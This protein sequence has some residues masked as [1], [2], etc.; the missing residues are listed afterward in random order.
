M[1]RKQIKQIL[2]SLVGNGVFTFMFGL[3]TI[4]ALVTNETTGL[5]LTDLS[6]ASVRS[7]TTTAGGA[8]L[9]VVLNGGPQPD[10]IY[11]S[12]DNGLSWQYLSDEPGLGFNILVAHP[13]DTTT[14]YGGSVGGAAVTTNSLWR[15][16]DG[17][18][19]W[20]EF[21]LDLPA[22]PNGQLPA[23]TALAV[24]P[25]KP[26]SFYVGT[27]GRGVYR[28]DLSVSGYGYTLIGD[29]SL[30]DAHINSLAIGVDS[31]LY[32]LTNE[33]L[34]T[35]GGDTWQKIESIP[36][37]PISLAIAPT[38]RQIIYAAGPSS[39]VYHSTD[40]GQTWERIGGEW[41]MI[42]GTALRGTALAV[43]AK[44]ANHVAVATAYQVGSEMVGGSIY[45]TRNAGHS[46]V[47]VA[48][49]NGVVNQLVVNRDTIYAIAPNLVRYKQPTRTAAIIPI[50]ELNS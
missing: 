4:A 5:S 46:W 22:D 21:R 24:D 7:M 30:Y 18:Q 42:P 10:G 27:D 28:F 16:E 50:A 20:Q 29:L 25:H 39:G 2:N 32:A 45:E 3:A 26:K 37:I 41:W 38:D 40:A 48:D 23:V 49:V 35:T 31:Q 12:H 9:Y 15:S 14:L 44:D 34:F 17:G 8:S 36:E 43:D 47:K 33:G 6:Q 13:T 11:R 1:V 19:S